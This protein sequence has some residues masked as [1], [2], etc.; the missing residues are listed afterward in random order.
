MCVCVCVCVCGATA[1]LVKTAVTCRPRCNLPLLIAI[2]KHDG[3]LEVGVKKL[4][5]ACTSL[6]HESCCFRSIFAEELSNCI[7]NFY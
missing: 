7:H 3:S 1:S 4:L 2:Q 5:K 6:N